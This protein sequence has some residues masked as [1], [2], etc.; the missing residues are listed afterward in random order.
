MMRPLVKVTSSRTWV[1]MSQP[2]PLTAGV[3]YFVQMS[4]SLK[5]RLLTLVW[6]TWGS[7]YRAASYGRQEKFTGVF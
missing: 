6:L 3:M 2:A 1:R 5:A 7:S 4:R